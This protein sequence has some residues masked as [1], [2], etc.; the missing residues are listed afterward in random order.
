MGESEQGELVWGD[1]TM[2][3]PTRHLDMQICRTHSAAAHK[4]P[5]TANMSLGPVET[6]YNFK[7]MLQCPHPNSQHRT[8]ATSPPGP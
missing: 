1:I 5:R 2:K 4:S 7:T 8:V 3:L 6:S